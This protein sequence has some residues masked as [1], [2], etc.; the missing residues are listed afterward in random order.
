MNTAEFFLKWLGKENDNGL[1]DECVNLIKSYYSEVLGLTPFVGNANQY[2]S[3]TRIPRFLVPPAHPQPCDIVIFN[4]GAYGHVGICVWSRSQDFECMEQNNPIGSPCHYVYHKDFQN[5]IGILRPNLPENSTPRPQPVS[6]PTTIKIARIGQNLPPV[7]ELVSEVDHFTNEKLGVLFKDYDV[8]LVSL[9]M[10]NQDSAYNWLSEHFIAE[11]FVQ[12]YY[13]SPQ[14]P[15]ATSYSFP[16]L[17]KQISTLPNNPPAQTIFYELSN[18]L[19][20]Y[21]VDTLNSGLGYQPDQMS[22]SEEF[23][24]SKVDKWLPFYKGSGII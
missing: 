7:S 4:Y 22:P 10:F 23:I 19:W 18:C 6:Q 1:K 8:P 17:K 21:S 24:Q 16:N 20:N 15:F 2:V 12:F 11:T 14:A 13:S 9:G 3:E 5:V